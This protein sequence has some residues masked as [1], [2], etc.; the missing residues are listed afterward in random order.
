MDSEGLKLV[1]SMGDPSPPP[2]SVDTDVIHVLKYT[3]PS[4]S[5]LHTASDQST[6]VT[7]EHVH[8]K[9]LHLKQWILL[10]RPIKC[11]NIKQPLCPVCIE[12]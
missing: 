12:Y 5:V 11:S 7:N 3:R 4:P 8:G 9:K 10:F 2:L 6:K 1:L